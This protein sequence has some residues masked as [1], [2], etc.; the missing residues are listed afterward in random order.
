MIDGVNDDLVRVKHLIR[1]LEGGPSQAQ[2]DPLQSLSRSP[3]RTSPRAGKGLPPAVAGLRH[4]R[5][6]T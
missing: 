4:D 3:F 5:H 1:L 6:H 2:S